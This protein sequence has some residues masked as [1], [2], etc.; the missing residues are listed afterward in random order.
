MERRHREVNAAR[1]S[2]S[3]RARV[4]V[5]AACVVAASS[6]VGAESRADRLWHRALGQ[7]QKGDVPRAIVLLQEI[8]DEYPDTPVAQK[9]RDQIVVYRG[10]VN[11]V[12]SYP[13]RRARELMVQ[14]ARAVEAGIRAS[15]HPPGT[16]GDLFPGGAGT[17]PADPWGRPFIYRPEGSGYRLRCDG[18]DGAPG[19]QGDTA[20]LVVVN[21]EFVAAP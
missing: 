9:A 17:V 21:G 1:R 13:T 6:C 10:L 3:F 5:V 2:V 8:I 16:L 14:I 7:V 12:Q 18:A 15:G 11:A 20:D 19:G 4:L